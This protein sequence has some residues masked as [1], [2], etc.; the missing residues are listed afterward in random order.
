MPVSQ[1]E[2]NELMGAAYIPF[3]FPTVGVSS[4]MARAGVTASN[5]TID[6]LWDA[7][8]LATTQQGNP[9]QQM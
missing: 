2:I 7:Y 9:N 3:T 5:A 6:Q 1:K 4:F 8:Y